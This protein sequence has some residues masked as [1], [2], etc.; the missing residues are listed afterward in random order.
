MVLL[1]NIIR[2][3]KYS[4]SVTYIIVEGRKKFLKSLLL[5][6]IVLAPNSVR[7]APS[8]KARIISY[9]GRVLRMVQYSFIYEYVIMLINQKSENI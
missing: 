3:S 8:K 5:S 7:I 4:F 2:L 6:N 9:E 1:E